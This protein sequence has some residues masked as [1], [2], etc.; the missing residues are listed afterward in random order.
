MPGLVPAQ[1]LRHANG[2]GGVRQAQSSKRR[3]SGMFGGK[4][5]L[6]SAWLCE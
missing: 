6:G 2:R 1:R 5:P 3:G 4:L